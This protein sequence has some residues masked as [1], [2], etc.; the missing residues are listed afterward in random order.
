MFMLFSNE[1]INVADL[2]TLINH[3]MLN[4]AIAIEM[5]NKVVGM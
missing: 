5:V 4:S 1:T 2:Q 3:K